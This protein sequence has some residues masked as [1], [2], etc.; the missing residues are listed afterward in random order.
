MHIHTDKHT[1]MFSLLYL[2]AVHCGPVVRL[3]H[4]SSVRDLHEVCHHS[5]RHFDLSSSL[6]GLID[7]SFE[8]GEV[9]L[10]VGAVGIFLGGLLMKRYK[11]GV[12]SG[13]QLSF[14]TSFMAYHLLLLQSGTKCDNV[15]VA[16][17]TVS[18]NGSPGV[19]WQPVDRV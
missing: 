6:I 19:R 16:G 8:M 5:E 4:Q 11:L 2:S 17:L 10:P 1:L 15:K 14:V 7:C 12:V 9:N 18:Y 13:T 3:L